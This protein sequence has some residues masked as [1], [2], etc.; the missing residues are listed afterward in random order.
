MQPTEPMR[1]IRP[2]LCALSALVLLAAA[3]AA[4]QSPPDLND[5]VIRWAAGR[6]ASPV[7]CEIGGELVSGIRR[8]I[9]RPQQTLGRPPRLTVQF[10]DMRP[11]EATR[12]VDARGAA[13]PNVLGKLLLELPGIS[14]PE[15]ASRDF[16]RAL[17]R[18]KGF[19][20]QIGEGVLKLQDVR[21]PQ[22]DP[23]IVDYR[24]GN[25]ALRLVAPATDADRA[26]AP[27]PSP[28]KLLL[29]VEAPGADRLELPLFLASEDPL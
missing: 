25:A 16:K 11:G 10:V 1:A 9:L 28:R 4:A 7:M 3:P 14:H 27:F 5:L 21:V 13:Q 22:P 18:E 24:G 17:Q 20:L 8:V 19:E 23:R 12:C 29:I 26:L 6:Y 15:T 2:L